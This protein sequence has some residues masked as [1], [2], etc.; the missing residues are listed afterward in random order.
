MKDRP[1]VV[2][3]TY[4]SSCLRSED[5]RLTFLGLSGQKYETLYKIQTKSKR[6]GVT[7]SGRA[8]AYL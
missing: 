4:N 1:G 3:H 8:L 7:Q 2:L 5:R 6:T